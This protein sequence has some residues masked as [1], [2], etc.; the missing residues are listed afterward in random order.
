MAFT[1]AYGA[2]QLVKYVGVG[3]PKPMQDEPNDMHAV[4][5]VL[6]QLLASTDA[7]WQRQYGEWMFGPMN[8]D[9][10]QY[11]KLKKDGEQK[12]FMR[13]VLQREHKEWVRHNP[14]HGPGMHK[15]A[16]PLHPTALLWVGHSLSRLRPL[17]AARLDMHVP[18]K[19]GFDLLKIV[20]CC[21]CG[22]CCPAAD[23]RLI[24]TGTCAGHLQL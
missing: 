1:S 9:L 21:C 5:I 8:Q 16:P 10:E 3:P 24:S 13:T 15:F 12:S 20:E 6:F 23:V 19:T 2:P 14:A 18:H 4:G 17:S 22:C 7:A 11:I